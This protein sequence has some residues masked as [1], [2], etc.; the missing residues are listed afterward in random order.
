MYVTF[1]VLQICNCIYLI[2]GWPWE[3]K[4]V[5]FLKR[6]SENSLPSRVKCVQLDKI[7][8]VGALL[9]P[10]LLNCITAGSVRKRSYA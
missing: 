5:I 6:N 8:R 1:W 2:K 3:Y 4:S 9:L 10:G 7:V